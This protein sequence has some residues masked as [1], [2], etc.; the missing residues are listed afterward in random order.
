MN[1]YC[2]SALRC[3]SS[4]HVR[5]VFKISHHF[6]SKTSLI[7][8]VSDVEGDYCYWKKY[9]SV[10]KVLEPSSSSETAPPTLKDGCQFVFGGDS[11]DKGEC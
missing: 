5:A 3:T 6:S 11:V 1:S 7:G 8:Y 2:R 10:S 4:L 9:L